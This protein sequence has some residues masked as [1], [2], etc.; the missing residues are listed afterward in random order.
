[1][2]GIEGA[3]VTAAGVL[4]YGDENEDRDDGD[5]AMLAMTAMMLRLE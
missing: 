5:D 1:M 2:H 4:N 3:A